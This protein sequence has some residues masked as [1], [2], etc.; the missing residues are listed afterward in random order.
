MIKLGIYKA[1]LRV[2]QRQFGNE[3]QLRAWQ[4]IGRP[5]P[6]AVEGGQCRGDREITR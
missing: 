2:A 5:S 4:D 6:K 1:P 3:D